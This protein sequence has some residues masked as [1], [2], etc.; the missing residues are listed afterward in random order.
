[1]PERAVYV[2]A[3]CVA[4]LLGL[5]FALVA[6]TSVTSDQPVGSVCAG[7]GVTQI[8]GQ[9]LD[10][11][12]TS[13]AHTI[14]RVA[15]GRE[16]PAYAAVIALTVAFTESRLHN[17]TVETDH[18][19]EGLFQQRVSLYTRQVADDPVKATNAFL[20]RLLRIPDWTT[21][22]V[23]ELAQQIQISSYPERY[24]GNVALARGLVGLFWPRLMGVGDEAAPMCARPAGTG[25]KAATVVP[26]GLVVDGGP[27]AQTAVRYA[28]AQLGKPYIFGAAGPDAFDC[29]GLTMAAWAAA[30]VALPHWTVTQA[31][32][33]EAEP[34]D[35]SQAVSGDL[36]FIAGADGTPSAPGHVGMVVGHLD[37]PDGRHLYLIQAPTTGVPVDL[38]DA[39]TW[40]GQ[41]VAVRHIDGGDPR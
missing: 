40:A 3:A 27:A 15:A 7:D 33:G 6:I 21:A 16:L 20:D 24:Q 26:P 28:L 23:G 35:M 34:P 36:V 38:I 17:S 25:S 29:S 32:A 12:Q 18:D 41:T 13:N 5:T 11:E 9:S 10:A 4:P 2:T 19:S 31:T 37:R 22:A 14:S 39:Q 1:M 8:G 30:G